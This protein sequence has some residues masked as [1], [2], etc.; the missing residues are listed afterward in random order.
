MLIISTFLKLKTRKFYQDCF[1]VFHKAQRAICS[2]FEK[3]SLLFAPCSFKP[4][5]TDML[6]ERLRRKE[7]ENTCG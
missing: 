2:K 3:G 5:P 6:A 1:K 4:R 7:I